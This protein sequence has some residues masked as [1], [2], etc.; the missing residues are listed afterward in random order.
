M[1]QMMCR[2][3]VV[4]GVAI[5]LEGFQTNAQG[6]LRVVLA[7]AQDIQ[8]LRQ[9]LFARDPAGGACGWQLAPINQPACERFKGD[10]GFAVTGNAHALAERREFFRRA[11][12]QQGFRGIQTLGQG[13]DQMT[14]ADAGLI[15][16]WL[17]GLLA[18]W[19]R[20]LNSSSHLPSGSR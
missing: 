11:C 13:A 10:A 8:R 17:N 2:Q 9:T 14:L 7:K 20:V 6:A 3:A 15:I 5:A 4:P 16:C 1:R 12:Q 18:A 19:W